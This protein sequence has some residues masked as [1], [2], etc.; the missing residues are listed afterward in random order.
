MAAATFQASLQGWSTG[1]QRG[2]AMRTSLIDGTCS[3]SQTQGPPDYSSFVESVVELC[4]APVT[5]HQH[6]KAPKA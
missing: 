5:S 1:V 3:K 2:L 4:G 6:P